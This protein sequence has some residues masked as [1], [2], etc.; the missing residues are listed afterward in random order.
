MRPIVP[1]HR[2]GTR[3]DERGAGLSFADSVNPEDDMDEELIAPCGMN[4]AICSAYLA[5]KH[6]V[7]G[8]GT[9]LPCCEGC[10]PR[11]K[12]CAFLK[13]SC[14]LLANRT[15]KYCFECSDFPCRRLHHLD[16]RYR[17]TFGMSMVQNLETI[18]DRGIERLLAEEEKK[19]KCPRCGGV[20]C[21]HNGACFECGLHMIRSGNA[22]RR[23]R[24]KTGG[25][26]S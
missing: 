11:N 14:G 17:E 20:V 3:K 26:M 9:R 6:D 12:R 15:V 22:P 8:K 21:C 4:C 25:D 5:L 23:T 16:R 1:R 10:R 24:Q 19:W 7:K 13:M 2:Q 18:R